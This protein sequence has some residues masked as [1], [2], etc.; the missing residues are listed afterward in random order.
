MTNR[1]E[2]R[3]GWRD[4]VW[5]R[6]P[7]AAP[8]ATGR[9]RLALETGLARIERGHL[10]GSTET[11]QGSVS[12]LRFFATPGIRPVRRRYRSGSRWLMRALEWVT[13]KAWPLAV[14]DDMC[15]W[16]EEGSGA[17]RMFVGCAAALTMAALLTVHSTALYGL[18]SLTLLPVFDG[19][20]LLALV[21]ASFLLGVT[22]LP[23]VLGQ[24]LGV[25]LRFYVLVN[26]CLLATV[27]G[28]GGWL[29][30]SYAKF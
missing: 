24:L 10:G 16:F 7:A 26:I 29:L 3:T 25:L 9:N 23:A 30:Y 19:H 14:L 8:C 6:Q 4:S 28:Y 15:E 2:G 17:S 27:V 5:N 22:I 20:G 11:G 18:Q 13:M 21:A 1:S 12:S